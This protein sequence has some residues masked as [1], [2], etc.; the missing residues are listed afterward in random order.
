MNLL[1]I[2]CICSLKDKPVE[3]VTPKYFMVKTIIRVA[4]LI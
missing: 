3:N 1:Q 4:E 2:Q